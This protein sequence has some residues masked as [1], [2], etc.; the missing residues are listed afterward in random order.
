MNFWRARV[1]P[2]HALLR[3]SPEPRARSV[4]AV[5][6]LS[7]LS[8]GYGV[9]VGSAPDLRW[10]ASSVLL[11]FSGIWRGKTWVVI[12]AGLTVA[13]LDRAGATGFARLTG[14]WPGKTKTKQA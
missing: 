11:G 4:E 1:L 12:V 6:A 3:P 2:P 9:E 7:N 8:D 10:T 14:V 5:D 13:L